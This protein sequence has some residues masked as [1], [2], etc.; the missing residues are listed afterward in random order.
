M[1]EN[2]H[3]T[4]RLIGSFFLSSIIGWGLNILVSLVLV[5]TLVLVPML[6]YSIFDFSFGDVLHYASIPFVGR[7]IA[8]YER[9]DVPIRLTIVIVY[10]I[11]VIALPLLACL[12]SALIRIVQGSRVMTILS[13]IVFL[14]NFINII[15]VLFFDKEYNPD[16]HG[17]WFNVVSI[18]LLVIL[19]LIDGFILMAC[20]ND[21]KWTKI[22]NPKRSLERLV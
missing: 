3:Y 10:F 18:C 20:W 9:G 21:G 5:S 7:L 6:L 4:P 16:L 2:K 15:S 19:F 22:F 12:V 13:G 14:L 8:I 1:E 17:F 11:V